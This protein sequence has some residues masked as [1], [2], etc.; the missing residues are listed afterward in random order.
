MRYLK[1]F[2]DLE[3]I[4]PEMD[5]VR[6]GI[7]QRLLDK[8]LEKIKEPYNVAKKWFYEKVSYFYIEDGYYTIGFVHKSYGDMNFGLA[9]RTED[10]KDLVRLIRLR[11]IFREKNERAAFEEIDTYLNGKMPI[12]KIF[13]DK[14]LIDLFLEER[15]DFKIQSGHII[16]NTFSYYILQ[17]Y[18][19]R[20]EKDQ[21]YELIDY[22]IESNRLDRY[23]II[24]IFIRRSDLD[25]YYG[26]NKIFKSLLDNL[27]FI[28]HVLNENPFRD[29]TWVIDN[30]LLFDYLVSDESVK[31]KMT[32]FEKN[33]A[34]KCVSLFKGYLLKMSKMNTDDL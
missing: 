33:K 18:L 10:Y 3:K 8:C 31:S 34:D 7:P 9:Y 12:V 13:K 14:D 5:Q 6:M 30:Y 29:M 27:F 11:W 23:D 20:I 25:K 17:N 28:L 24:D 4:Q 21:L 15:P 19:D 2:E 16:N 26:N 32:T 1:L 22:A